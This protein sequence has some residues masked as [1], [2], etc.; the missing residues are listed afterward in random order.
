MA[1]KEVA[2][3]KKLQVKNGGALMFLC[4]LVYAFSYLGKVNYAA[5]I[6]RVEAYFNVS[7]AEAGMASTFFF[8]AY[9]ATQILNGIFCKKYNIRLVVFGSLLVCVLT[10]FLVG[11]LTNFTVIKYLWLL[12]GAALSVLWPCLIRLLSETLPKKSMAKA[13]NTMGTTVATGT[14]IIYGISTLFAQFNLPFQFVFFLSSALVGVVALV[15]LFS[16]KR[17]TEGVEKEE[18]SIAAEENSAKAQKG[19]SL[20]SMLL[21][22]ICLLAFFAIMVNLIKDGL[23]TWVPSILKET[24]SLPDSFSILLTLA[25]PMV[26]IFANMFAVELHKKIPDFVMQSGVVFAGTG[27]VIV[28]I[29]VC[30][31]KDALA[32]TLVGFALVSFLVSSVNSLITS[33]FPL[34]MKGKM[35]SGLLAGVL[36]GMCYVGSTASS[37]GL[38][39]VADAWGWTVVFYVLLAACGLVVLLSAGYEIGRLIKKKKSTL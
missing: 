2:F 19:A 17:V 35:N 36:N 20:S 10:N 25:L 7:H 34:Y 16:F 32:V 31:T 23:T 15:W 3:M 37:Y 28:V 27:L 11:I 12:N 1:N 29:I 33:V 22:M 8:F 39:A 30:L 6:T 18:I 38:G 13:S 24:Y 5:N 9:G 14:F 26:A 4:W 21:G